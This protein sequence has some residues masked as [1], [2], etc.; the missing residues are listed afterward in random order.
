MKKNTCPFVQQNVTFLKIYLPKFYLFY[1]KKRCRIIIYVGEVSQKSTSSACLRSCWSK[2]EFQPTQNVH[3][4]GMYTPSSLILCGCS[5]IM[6]IMRL[7]CT[8]EAA[9]LLY[10]IC[11]MYAVCKLTWGFWNLEKKVWS[12]WP[13]NTTN[14]AVTSVRETVVWGIRYYYMPFVRS[15]VLLAKVLYQNPCNLYANMHRK[16][17][18]FP[19]LWLAGHN[20]NILSCHHSDWRSP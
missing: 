2:I 17:I 1:V 7:C 20:S 3:P 5:L 12:K 10:S 16:W 15:Q 18:L 11:M 4:L 9:S 14:H 13:H 6:L 19:A 8:M